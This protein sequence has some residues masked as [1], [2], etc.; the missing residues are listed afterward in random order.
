MRSQT[1]LT[2]AEALQGLDLL[3]ALNGFE[4]LPADD[5][6]GLRLVRKQ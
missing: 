4:V 6:K 1:T 3:L 5:T 2:T